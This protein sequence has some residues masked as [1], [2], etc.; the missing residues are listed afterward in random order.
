MGDFNHHYRWGSDYRLEWLVESRRLL[1]ATQFGF[2]KGLGTAD[3][4]TSSVRLALSRDESLVAV[5]LDVSAAYDS[6]LLPLLRQKLQKL[7]IPNR[8]CQIIGC[9]LS[10]RTLQLRTPEDNP[11][12]RTAWRGL[13]QGSVLSPIL[14]NITRMTFLPV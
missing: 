12:Q 2:G 10:N 11:V 5:F 9:I 13:P 7:R 14:Y 6:V 1:L 4:L 3:T 8:I